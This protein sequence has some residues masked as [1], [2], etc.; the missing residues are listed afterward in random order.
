MTLAVGRRSILD[1]GRRPHHST[2][3]LVGPF[4]GNY[5]SGKY[6]LKACISIHAVAR[7]SNYFSPVLIAFSFSVLSLL[8]AVLANTEAVCLYPV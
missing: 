3:N 5:I 7:R 6:V 8:R 1:G 2:V 4:P